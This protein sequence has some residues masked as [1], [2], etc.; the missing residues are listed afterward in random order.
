MIAAFALVLMVQASAPPFLRWWE[1][2]PAEATH[3]A[4]YDC[5]QGPVD[6]EIRQAH[7]VSLLS[8]SAAGRPIAPDAKAQANEILHRDFGWL[9]SW[10]VSCEGHRVFVELKGPNRTNFPPEYRP[11]TILLVFSGG[12]LVSTNS[13]LD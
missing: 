1:S 9:D 13:S 10:S 12:K 3:R 4:T 5:A 7:E 11:R 8:L 2:P 6:L